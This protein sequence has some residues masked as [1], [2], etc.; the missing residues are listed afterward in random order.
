MT[1]DFLD[2]YRTLGIGPGAKWPEIRAAYRARMREWHPDRFAAEDSHHQL[3][4]ERAKAINE[5]YRRLS[6]FYRMHGAPPL[7]AE[8]NTATP[9]RT[10]TPAWDSRRTDTP[11]WQRRESM[12][13]TARRRTMR[14]AALLLAL[15]GGYIVIDPIAHIA[16]E[17]STP[18]APPT[19]PPD[20]RPAAPLPYFT[21]GSTLGEVYTAQGVPSRTEADVWHY[22]TSKIYF[23]KGRVVNWE[24]TKDHPLRAQLEAH[25]PPAPATNYFTRGSTKTHVRSVQGNPVRETDK[26]W[27]YGVSRVYFEADRV[28]SWNESPL[29]PLKVK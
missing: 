29:N 9:P 4:E 21:I 23:S 16:R 12:S 24:E 1:Q 26:V 25:A 19:A 22:G 15:A 14:A 8:R 17:T 7:L 13:R 18:D 20:P 5:A 28:V 27:D 6:D 10:E 2:C 3:A 11:V